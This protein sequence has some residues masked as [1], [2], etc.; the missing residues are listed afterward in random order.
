MTNIITMGERTRGRRVGGGGEGG[1]RVGYCCNKNKNYVQIHSLKVF[2]FFYSQ[3]KK[4]SND[5]SP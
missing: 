2:L 5:L 4:R 1:K 3:S